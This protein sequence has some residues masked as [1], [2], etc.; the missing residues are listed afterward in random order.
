[1]I[2]HL[3]DWVLSSF[4]SDFGGSVVALIIVGSIGIAV[5]FVG[6]AMAMMLGVVPR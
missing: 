5:A 1:V 4:R 6:L 3:V 2:S